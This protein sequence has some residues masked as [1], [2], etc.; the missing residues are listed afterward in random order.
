MSVNNINNFWNVD[1]PSFV[2][3]NSV[4]KLV[5]QQ[6][7]SKKINKARLTMIVF[8]IIVSLAYLFMGSFQYQ[9]ELNYIC[10]TPETTGSASLMPKGE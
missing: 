5:R 10:S 1:I 9:A 6:K 2:P 8:L 7:K 4:V 3:K